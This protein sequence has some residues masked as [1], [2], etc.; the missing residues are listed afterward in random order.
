MHVSVAPDSRRRTR[1]DEVYGCAFHYEFYECKLAAACVAG[2]TAANVSTFGAD[3]GCG[4]CTA[5]TVS[6]GLHITQCW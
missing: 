3:V 6:R 1:A 2:V 4:A 5:S